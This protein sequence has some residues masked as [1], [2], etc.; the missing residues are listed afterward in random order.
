M[1]I[2]PL[3]HKTYTQ[4]EFLVDDENV[5]SSLDPSIHLS[6]NK[7]NEFYNLASCQECNEILREFEMRDLSRHADAFMERCSMR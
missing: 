3:K 1:F 7:K 5:D 6:I 2:G 4:Q